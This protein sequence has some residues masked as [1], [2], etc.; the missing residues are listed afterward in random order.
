MKKN[1][2]LLVII[3]LLLTLVIATCTFFIGK[4][5][6]DVELGEDNLETDTES[7]SSNELVLV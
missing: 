7:F 3:F 6:A 1:N 2:L 4:K 5:E